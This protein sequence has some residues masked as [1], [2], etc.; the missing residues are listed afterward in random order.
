[1]AEPRKGASQESTQKSSSGFRLGPGGPRGMMDTGAKAKDT[2]GTL[3]RL[4]GYLRHQKW[5]LIITVLL[6]AATTGLDLLG[7]YL[8]GMAIDKYIGTGDLQGLSRTMWLMLGCYVVASLATW[9]QSYIAAS[10]GQHIVRDM[11]RDLFDKLQSLPLKYLDSQS[12]GDVMSRLTNDVENVNNVISGSATM[13]VS[14][15]LGLV[16]TLGVMLYA[17]IPMT[18]VTFVT[19]PISYFATRWLMTRTRKIYR[20][21]QKQLGD[22]NGIIEETVSGQ[23]V[24][25][26][27]VRAARESSRFSEANRA[28]A[29]QSTKVLRVMA[30]L[31]PAMA[32]ALN[33]TLVGVVWLGGYQ[34]TTAEMSA[35]QLVAAA[36][37][38]LTA[39]FPIILLT[40]IMG[41]LASAEASSGRI[42]EVLGAEPEVQDRPGA[43]APAEVKGR[44]AFENV[45]FS[46]DGSE[47]EPVLRDVSVVA[48]P[49]ER[50]AILGATGSGKSTLV[51]LVP[52][53]Y[54]VTAGRVTLDG[55]D[56]RDIPLATLRAQIGVA[57]Q[58]AV[59]FSGTVRDNIRYGRPDASEEEVMAA[60]RAAQIHDFIASLPDGYDT[61]VGQRGVNFS[62]GQK[63]RL[64]IARALL[65]QPRVLILDDSTSAVDVETESRLEEAMEVALAGSTSLVVA[66][67]IS[68]VLTA[69]KI[70]VLERGRVAALGTHREL[71]AGSPIYREIYDSQLGDGGAQ[72][73]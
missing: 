18:L 26:A 3:R 2:R 33:I 1:M 72:H 71:M 43:V 29:A 53:F 31:S 73:G 47:S 19:V 59:L 63:Q 58:E 68:T 7:T 39:M 10:T 28:L 20:E 15:L 37:Y 5:P 54:D 46:Y 66:Q 49:G 64:A 56:V 32:L 48:E 44:V 40:G 21:Q 65:V 6:V 14:S 12:H 30:V 69:D 27:F 52:R 25:K 42:M 22:L 8:M 62:G 11:R 41:P 24:V 23:R 17:N 4:W 35:G 16:G 36:N 51:H 57:L 60:A 55:V 9:L 38:L 45:S 61:A 13:L 70:V 34:V 67:R 50:V